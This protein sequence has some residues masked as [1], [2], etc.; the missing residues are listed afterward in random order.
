MP[1]SLLCVHK[2][3]GV[4]RPTVEDRVEF[5]NDVAEFVTLGRRFGD[6]GLEDLQPNDVVELI[7]FHEEESSTEDL[8]EQDALNIL[9][10]ED[11]ED[12]PASVD[13]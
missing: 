13:L 6:E 3:G 4:G 9:P 1:C 10:K 8:V 2:S 5:E 11:E 7:N 12:E